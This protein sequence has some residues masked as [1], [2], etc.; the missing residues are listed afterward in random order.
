MFTRAMVTNQK[1]SL[2]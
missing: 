2:P 1:L